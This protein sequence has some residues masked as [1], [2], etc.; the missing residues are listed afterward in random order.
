MQ[1]IV[2]VFGVV[3]NAEGIGKSSIRAEA[4][5]F[6]PEGPSAGVAGGGIRSEAAPGASCEARKCSS[7]LGHGYARAGIEISV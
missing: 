7:A 4:R 6:R 3:T 1:R 2:A 5:E